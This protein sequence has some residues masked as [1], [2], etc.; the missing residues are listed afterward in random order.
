MARVYRRRPKAPLTRGLPLACAFLGTA[1]G[2]GDVEKP[3]AETISRETFIETYVALR[4]AAR[5]SETGEIT[6]EARERVL[7]EQGLSEDD[8]L[9][10]VEV[11]GRRIDFMRDVWTEVEERLEIRRAPGGEE[12]DTAGPGPPPP[13]GEEAGEGGLE[14]A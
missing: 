3:G 6:A 4:E 13:G 8:L 5:E 9:T 10:F 12:A 14:A 11:H 7:A 1:C 2:V